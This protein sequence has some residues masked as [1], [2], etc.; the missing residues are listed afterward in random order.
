MVFEERFILIIWL[1]FNY[2]SSFAYF[3]LYKLFVID[4]LCILFFNYMDKTNLNGEGYRTPF[5]GIWSL[6]DDR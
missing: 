4:Q 3:M 2:D 1:I 5:K 6:L